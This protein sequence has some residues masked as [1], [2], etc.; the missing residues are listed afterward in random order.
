MLDRMYS[1]PSLLKQMEE[2]HR[3]LLI[4][5][6]KD[7]DMGYASYR[8]L[9]EQR[10]KLEKLYVR[11]DRHR[12]GLGRLLLQAVIHSVREQKGSHL[13]LQVNRKNPAVGFYHRMGFEIIRDEDF[14]IGHGF[15]MNDHIMELA[16]G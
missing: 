4:Q 8:P 5:H 14:D 9:T 1:T 13:E 6:E 16:T 7:Q 10:W 11:T 3:F 2:G 12:K 15:Y